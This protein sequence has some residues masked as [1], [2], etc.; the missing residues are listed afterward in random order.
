M[1]DAVLTQAFSSILVRAMRANSTADTSALP[2]IVALRG[3]RVSVHVGVGSEERARAQEVALE[4][5]LLA[6]LLHRSDGTALDD[7][8]A[9]VDY[10][11]LHDVVVEAAAVAPARLIETIALRVRKAV[12]EEC[13]EVFDVRV[14][15]TKFDPPVRGE[16]AEARVTVPADWEAGS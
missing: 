6:D 7:L 11:R 5:E 1:V 8:E 10:D 4:V 14:R 9:T 16:V 13:P 15:C 12:T 2:I 3:I